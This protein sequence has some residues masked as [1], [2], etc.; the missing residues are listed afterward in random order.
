VTKDSEVNK[1]PRLDGGVMTEPLPG[2]RLSNVAQRRE[3]LQDSLTSKRR[4]L[5]LWRLTRRP[6]VVR[7]IARGDEN[8]KRVETEI[9]GVERELRELEES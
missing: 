4:E 2:G 6:E 3:Q 5:S 7:Q 9:A 8:A 1:V